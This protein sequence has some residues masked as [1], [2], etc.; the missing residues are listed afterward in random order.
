MANER[1]A[2]YYEEMP[3]VWPQGLFEESS[4][5]KCKLG[6]ERKLSDGRVFVYVKNGATAMVAGQVYQSQ[7]CDVANTANL[8]ITANANIGER[9]I[10]VTLGNSTAA[11]TANAYADGYIYISTGAGNGTTYKIK[12]HAAIAANA[13]GTFKLYDKIRSA[14]IAAATS[15]ASLFP[16][17]F[18]G[19]IVHP[20]PPTSGLVG[21]ATFAVTANYYAWLQKKGPCAV[22][23]DAGSG[24]A[25]TPGAEVY[26]SPAAN[27][28]ITGQVSNANFIVGMTTAMYPVGRCLANNANDHWALVDLDI[29]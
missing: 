9:E 11:N 4:V 6:Q 15:K 3:T 29:P 1:Y 27:G 20:S 25:L 19:V 13:N 18:N 16:D 17:K 7:V 21:V 26:A 14:N 10:T 28:C 8:A 12:S 22:E 23:N 2:E 24:A 5:Q